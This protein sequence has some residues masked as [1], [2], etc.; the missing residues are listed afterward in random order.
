M[1]IFLTGATGFIGSALLK[2]LIM[3]NYE[4]TVLVRD[5]N[6]LPPDVVKKI[7]VIESDMD[8][9]A[10]YKNKLNK[11][12]ILIH[13][14]AL[15][16][17]WGEKDIFFNQNALVIE[18][19]FKYGNRLKHVVITS[20]VYAMGNQRH[21]PANES[22]RLLARDL[23][24]KSKALAEQVTR[25]CG[26]KHKIPYTIVRPAIVYGPHMDKESFMSKM[27]LLI[28]SKKL[29]IIGSGSNLVH[30]I[31]I[32]DLIDGYMN[33]IKKGGSN[34]TYILAGAEPIKFIDLVELVKSQLG[35]S[36]KNKYYPLLPFKISAVVCELLFEL[37]RIK[38]EPPL[39]PIK[40]RAISG[41]WSY[42]ISKAK[43]YLGFQPKYNYKLGVKKMV[44]N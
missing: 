33:I 36:Y 42:D 9:Y 26:L 23:Y 37:I 1:K 2:R 5:R 10:I 16:A 24:G 41:N 28:E 43:Q 44:A 21:W 4:I 39:S 30:L 17:N 20:S 32:D 35:V 12:D 6:K 13:L 3:D 38:H 15:R 22:C 14:A 27:R 18:N 29:P 31:Y 7:K 11:S 40:L 19:F 8:N 34:Q 25:N